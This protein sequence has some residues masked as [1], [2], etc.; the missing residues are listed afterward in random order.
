MCYVHAESQYAFVCD[1]SIA[2]CRCLIVK[3]M[4]AGMTTKKVTA[5]IVLM[6]QTDFDF[7]E[8]GGI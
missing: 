1:I 4:K 6:S 8:L 7:Y 2:S 5:M 3:K